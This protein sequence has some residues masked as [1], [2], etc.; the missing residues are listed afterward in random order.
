MLTLSEIN[1]AIKAGTLSVNDG[2]AKLKLPP[3]AG[4]RVTEYPTPGRPWLWQVASLTRATARRRRLFR[5]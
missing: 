2:R 4:Y 5:R 1:D 3:I